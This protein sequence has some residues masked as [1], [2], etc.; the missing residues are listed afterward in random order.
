MLYG[1]GVIFMKK[2]YMLAFAGAAA[3]GMAMHFAYAVYPAALVGVFAP[4]NESVW[5]HLKLLFWPFLGAGFAVNAREE[6]KRRA[7]SGFLAA[8]LAMPIWVMGIYYLMEAG[9][10]VRAMA[11]EIGLYLAAL[12][13]GFALSYRMAR[14]GRGERLAGVLVILVGLYGAALIL[15]TLAPPGLPVFTP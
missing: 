13:G 14:S 7:W 4:V 15:F 6:N 2:R 11:I 1:E 5:E 12:G 10:G 3:A 9:F 8:E